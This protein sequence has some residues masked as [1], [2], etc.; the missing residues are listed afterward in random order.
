M[1]H[2]AAAAIRIDSSLTSAAVAARAGNGM[3]LEIQAS[4]IKASGVKL[5]PV[6][7]N[8]DRFDSES[9]GGISRSTASLQTLSMHSSTRS[10]G[11]SPE[12]KHI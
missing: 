4:G 7:C 11:D 6:A 12:E 5:L 9:K 2:R 1:T 8:D 3:D 10:T